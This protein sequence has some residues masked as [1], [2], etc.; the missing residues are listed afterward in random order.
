MSARPHFALALSVALAAAPGGAYAK[1]V[2]TLVA[3]GSSDGDPEDPPLH[4]ATTDATRFQTLFVEIGHVSADRA[5]LLVDQPVSAIRE[6]L[7]EVAGRLAEVR[8]SGDD[9]MLIIYASGHA[10]GGELHVQGAHLPLA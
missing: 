2:R 6:K 9:G 1:T 4:Y 8:A 10:K 5:Y 3:I 7:A